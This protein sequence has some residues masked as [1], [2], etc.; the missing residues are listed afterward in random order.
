[1]V[2]QSLHVLLHRRTWG[3]RDFVIF[4]FDRA[5]R[6]LVQALVDDTKGLT[7]FFH[8]AEVAVITVAVHTDRN[9][10]FY[11]VVSIV[12]LGLSDVPRDARTSKHDTREGIVDGVG[13]GNDADALGA[14]FP[15]AIVGEEFFS[16]VDAVTKLGSPLVDIVEEAKG[17]VL[18]DATG[19]DVGSVK[20]STRDTFVEFL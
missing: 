20:T 15:D 9:V 11:L 19:A 2:N 8:A 4:D 6:H 5:G 13:S 18:G 3:R 7:E 12:G 17:E 1:M 14:A 10:E 16:L